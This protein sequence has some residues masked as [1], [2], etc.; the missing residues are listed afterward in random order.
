MASKKPKAK[1]TKP[2]LQV[3]NLS[4]RYVTKWWVHFAEPQALEIFIIYLQHLYTPIHPD[5]NYIHH[6]TVILRAQEEALLNDLSNPYTSC[7]WPLKKII[8]ALILRKQR[9]VSAFV[10][11]LS[12]H[13]T[14]SHNFKSNYFFP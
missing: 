4:Y 11:N 5:R 9:H 12:K 7:H 10:H 14:G 8:T 2:Q 1:P 3:S 6:I 13:S